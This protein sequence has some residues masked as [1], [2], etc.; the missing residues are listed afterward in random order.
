[1]SV[2]ALSLCVPQEILKA[3]RKGVRIQFTY[4]DAPAKQESPFRPG[5]G[6]N[7]LFT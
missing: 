7:G 1:M 4:S 2:V 6:R 3:H 5:F